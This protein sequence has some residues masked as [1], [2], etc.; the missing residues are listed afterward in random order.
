MQWVTSSGDGVVTVPGGGVVSAVGSS[1]LIVPGSGV[2]VLPSVVAMVVIGVVVI[3][4]AITVVVCRVV[5]VTSADASEDWLSED[6]I[7]SDD[8]SDESES[9]EASLKREDPVRC[10]PVCEWII[11]KI[12]GNLKVLEM[13]YHWYMMTSASFPWSTSAV[14]TTP[15]AHSLDRDNS[16]NNFYITY[17][18]LL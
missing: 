16:V 14:S 15:P 2:M 6:S 9:E 17:S 5:R 7:D 4:V 13:Y 12:S 18:I 1:V 11:W 10:Q 8:S 3:A